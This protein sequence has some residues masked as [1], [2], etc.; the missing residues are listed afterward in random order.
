VSCLSFLLLRLGLIAETVDLGNEGCEHTAH[1]E[2]VFAHEFELFP[3]CLYDRFFAQRRG[4]F[5]EGPIG[6]CLD[7]LHHVLARPIVSAVTAGQ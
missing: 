4:C 7:T 1:F 5:L 2:V 3:A 6:P